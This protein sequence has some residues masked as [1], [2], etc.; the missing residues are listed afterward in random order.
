MPLERMNCPF[1]TSLSAHAIVYVEYICTQSLS[2]IFWTPLEILDLA[3]NDMYS[4][5]TPRLSRKKVLWSPSPIEH[6]AMENYITGQFGVELG[7]M[8]HE[9]QDVAPG[10]KA[11]ELISV[12]FSCLLLY[13]MNP[14]VPC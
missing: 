10:F 4:Q 2:R 13:Y 8:R 5:K 1:S 7:D 9:G 11:T 6:Y 3:C 14:T 12:V